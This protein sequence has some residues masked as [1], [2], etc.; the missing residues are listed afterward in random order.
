MNEPIQL[1]KI[2]QYMGELYTR[3][4]ILEEKEQRLLQEIKNLKESKVTELKPNSKIK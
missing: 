4:R 2:M 3:N 1:E